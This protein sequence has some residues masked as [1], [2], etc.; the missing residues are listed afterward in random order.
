M[1]RVAFRTATNGPYRRRAFTATIRPVSSSCPAGALVQETGRGGVCIGGRGASAADTASRSCPFHVPQVS[2][3]QHTMRKC[4]FCVQRIDHGKEPA[5]VAKCPTGALTYYPDGK[6][7]AGLAAYGKAERLHMVY[8]LQG[9]PG[10]ISIAG[11]GSAEIRLPASRSGSGWEDWC[12]GLSSWPGCGKRRSVRRKCMSE[13][14]WGMPVVLDLFFAGLAAGA[15][16]FAVLTSRRPGE[17]FMACSR[18]AALLAPLSVAFG[19]SMLIL[20]LRYKTRFWFTMTVFNSDSPMSLGVWLLTLFSVIAALY[21]IFWIP[22]VCAGAYSRDR[23]MA[24]CGRGRGSATRWGERASRWPCWFPFIP[25]C[26][27]PPRPFPSG[28]TWPCRPSFV[29]PAMATGF[30]GGLLLALL[31]SPGKRP[32]DHCRTIPL[33]AGILSHPSAGLSSCG[34]LSMSFCFLSPLT[35]QEEVI[36]LITGW[37]GLIWWLGVVGVGI[38]LP[39]FLGLRKA[40]ASPSTVFVVLGA[41]LVGGFLLRL[42]LVFTGQ[43]YVVAAGVS[44]GTMP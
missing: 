38:L 9:K 35:R 21:A 7:P 11:S 8:A 39:L 10:G 12:P 14:T 40:K 34:V 30:A 32:R 15:F 19:L 44:S 26:C 23:E 33:A 24:A 29:S 31:F 2:P 22:A 18:A 27:S 5:C 28:G 43:E 37:N 41:L 4:S 16:C 25:A 13:I 6:A 20:D 17:G 1:S 36:P 42:V 3:T